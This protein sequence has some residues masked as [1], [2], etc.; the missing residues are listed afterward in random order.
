MDKNNRFSEYDKY[1]IDDDEIVDVNSNTE[2]DPIDEY[3]DISSNSAD[4][5]EDIF[6]KS[7]DFEEPDYAIPE[8]DIPISRPQMTVQREASPKT[9]PKRTRKPEPEPSSNDIYSNS[10][11]LSKK[12]KRGLGA[13]CATAGV[14][15]VIDII[16]LLKLNMLPM[17]FMA[18]AIL[19]FALLLFIICAL[20]FMPSK[21]KF[22]KRK[23][24]A[25]I[26]AVITIIAAVIGMVM[27]GKLLGT[28]GTIIDGK[29]ITKE[30]LDD[31]YI[32]YLS[33]SDT[34]DNNLSE[35][36][37]S[38]VNIL[39]VVNPKTHQV[40][41]LNTPR[42]YYV[43]NPAYKGMDKLTHCGLGGIE[44]SMAALAELYELDEIDY[45]GR[46][47]F[48]GF[49]KLV[50]SI[51]GIDIY[52]DVAF[53][54]EAG[55][56]V[57]INQGMNHLNG[58]EALAYARER[59]AFASGDLARGEHQ[60]QVIKAIASKMTSS[61]ALI[62][63]YMGLMN[64]LKGMFETD[65]P[66][67]LISYAVKDMLGSGD[68]WD[69]KSYAVT[70]KGSYAVC[71]TSGQSLSVIIR[72]EASVEQAKEYIRQVMDGEALTIE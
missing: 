68:G 44:N 5:Y 50:D 27:M 18:L 45:F 26:L 67:M 39:M 17:K 19:G 4:E 29:K 2:E 72:D 21:H 40:L 51:G 15:E 24:A 42:D 30:Q 3:E 7:D 20:M 63:N 60:M 8:D 35:K 43:N 64:S 53:T 12:Q 23:I 31:P 59:H 58:F 22:G 46:I 34:R 36:T 61:S 47:N 65:A 66:Q 37:R 49:E 13:L 48:S 16:M 41:L 28:L 38:D 55:S 54:T 11:Q 56:N 62:S 69:M 71:V 52:S 1:L 33:G 57:H 6:S 32:V 25:T 14:C 9:S 10:K 70:G